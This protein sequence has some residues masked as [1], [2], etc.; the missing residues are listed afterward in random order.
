MHNP[1][2]EELDVQSF[3]GFS[4]TN[5]SPNLNQTTRPNDTQK[6]KRKEKEKE[7]MP[8]CGLSRPAITLR[9]IK[10]TRKR[11]MYLD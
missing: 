8:N 4:D 9:K 3:L 2:F 10:E 1:E 6:K 7:N 11:V 5:K